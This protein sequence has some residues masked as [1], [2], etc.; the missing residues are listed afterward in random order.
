MITTCFSMYLTLIFKRHY[1]KIPLFKQSVGL[2]INGGDLTA[3]P[4][5]IAINTLPLSS[6][7]TMP[8]YFL[9]TSRCIKKSE[10][11]HLTVSI[12][13]KKNKETRQNNCIKQ[14]WERFCS[15]YGAHGD[16]FTSWNCIYGKNW[17]NLKCIVSIVK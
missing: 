3:V 16:N 11:K 12:F 13:K 10:L 6:W 2:L 9:V 1:L 5:C 4:K 17:D 8:S 14:Q 15:L 7:W